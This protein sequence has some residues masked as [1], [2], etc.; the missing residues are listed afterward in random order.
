VTLSLTPWAQPDEIRQGILDLN[1]AADR[2]EAKGW[3]QHSYQDFD[4][5]CAAGAVN[6]VTNEGR[7]TTLF[8]LA[9]QFNSRSSIACGIFHRMTGS[10]I[11]TFNDADGR[12]AKQVI[13]KIRDV[14]Q[15]ATRQLERE[16]AQK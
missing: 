3:I 14:A 8:D 16:L 13:T 11:A 6:V 12:T 10:D 9:R 5:C 2:L 4:A 1:A 7:H 15:Q